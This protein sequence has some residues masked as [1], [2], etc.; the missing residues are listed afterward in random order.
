MIIMKPTDFI[1]KFDAYLAQKKLAFQGVIIG[2]TALNL[3]GTVTRETM[4]CD[5]LDPTIPQDILK[6]ATDFARLEKIPESAL[7]EN[8]FNNGPIDVAKYLPDGWRARVVPVFQG[9]AL[10]L[11]TLGRH[12]LLCSKLDALCARATD[13]NDCV[14]MKPTPVELQNC[15]EW[16]CERDANPE[17]PVHVESEFKRLARKLGY[18]FQA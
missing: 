4:D 6:A 7:K 14:A 8:W 13:F 15:F 5:V 11:F 1:P 18:E 16:V 17:W 3:L 10:K 12:D 2:A 9:K